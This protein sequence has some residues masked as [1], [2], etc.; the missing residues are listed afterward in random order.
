MAQAE[1][2][3]HMAPQEELRLVLLGKNGSGKNKTGN[4]ILGKKEFAFGCSSGSITDTC[5][6]RR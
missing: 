5:Q 1:I 6:L 4:I 2:E 3:L